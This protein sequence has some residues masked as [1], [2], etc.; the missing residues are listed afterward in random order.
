M[1]LP[2]HSSK[3]TFHHVI[4]ALI[5]L[6]PKTQMEIAA[7]LG[8]SKPNIVSMFKSGATKVPIERLPALAKILDVDPAYLLRLALQEYMPKLLTLIESSCGFTVT[9]NEKEII[10]ELRLCTSDLDPKM[11][12][13]EQRASLKAF[14]DKL[15]G[16]E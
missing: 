14:A 16:V 10:K 9:E 4:S 7:E 8:F 13:A 3:G 2:A 11:S 1:T 6:S 12:K 15:I 5:E